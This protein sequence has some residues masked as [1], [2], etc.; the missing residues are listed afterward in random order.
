MHILG[1][2]KSSLS[3]S[4]AKGPKLELDFLKLA[5][6]IAALEAQGETA[7]G[8]L[9]VLDPKAVI[10]A[11]TWISKYGTGERIEVLY[12]ALADA[13]LNALS[14]EKSRH[15]EGMIA[16]TL[17]QDVGGRSVA[18]YGKRLGEDSLREALQAK[19]PKLRDLTLSCQLPLGVLWDF[20][21]KDGSD[22][23]PPA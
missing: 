5:Y 16:G 15:T 23:I 18:Y 2:A 17:N 7:R 14:A 11:R 6:A 22:E 8:Y 10:R 12:R 20:Y 9:L 4:G 3:L 13:E 1:M 19:F 21:G